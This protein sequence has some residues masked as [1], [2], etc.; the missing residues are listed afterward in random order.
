MHGDVAV[1]R[2]SDQPIADQ[3]YESLRDAIIRGELAPRERVT[4]EIVAQRANVSRTPVREAFRRLEVDGLIR[5]T[6]R[7]ATV[8][9]FTLEELAQVCV[10]R[11]QLEALAARLAATQRTDLDLAM[12]DESTAEFEAAIDGELWRIVDL[13]H[14]FHDTIWEAAR[15]RFLKRQ[16][17]LARSLIERHDATTLET[18]DRQREA[19]AEH[20]AILAALRASDADAAETTT[21]EHFHRASARRVLAKR[22]TRRKRGEA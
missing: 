18:E 15:N 7:G 16:L 2:R 14:D 13:N 6:G 21:L 10:V 17:E 9:E 5:T 8:V 11:D 4:A 20:L 12:L 19:L 3:L 1:S 22:A